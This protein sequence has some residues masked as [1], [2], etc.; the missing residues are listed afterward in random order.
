MKETGGPANDETRDIMLDTNP[1]TICRLIELAREIHEQQSLETLASTDD[2]PDEDDEEPRH[3]PDLDCGDSLLREFAA[4]IDDLEPDQ[5]QQLVALLWLGRGDFTLDEW[6][7]DL[8]Q[9][10]QAWNENTADY[11]IRHPQLA[12]FLSE[13]LDLFGYRCD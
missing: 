9:A 7:A 11:L 1:L 13:G 6:N 4:I 8:K 10:Q 2:L 5:Q 3:Q 12:D